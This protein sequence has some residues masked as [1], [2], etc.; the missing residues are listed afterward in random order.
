MPRRKW[1]AVYLILLSM[2]RNNFNLM[3]TFYKCKRSMFNHNPVKTGLITI[4]ISMATIAILLTGCASS[5]GTEIDI[6]N[7][8]GNLP[9]STR[10]PSRNTTHTIPPLVGTSLNMS[11]YVSFEES[12][13]ILPLYIHYGEYRVYI[14]NNKEYS[15]SHEKI[16]QEIERLRT[17]S[18]IKSDFDMLET[19]MPIKLVVNIVGKP[20]EEQTNRLFSRYT[21]DDGTDVELTYRIDSFKDR[22]SDEPALTSLLTNAIYVNECGVRNEIPLKVYKTH[23]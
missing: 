8:S 18:L 20:H 13:E 19:G 14:S 7:T 12:T 9:E 22:H 10:I 17:G 2:W 15:A 1:G 16:W 4:V 3:N 21:L 6:P 23:D 11:G 5:G